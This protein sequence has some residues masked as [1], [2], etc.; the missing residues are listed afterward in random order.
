MRSL[1]LS[2]ALLIFGAAAAT[3]QPVSD[4]QLP[5][6]P[7]ATPT[8][9]PQAQG[10]TDLEG[11]TRSAPRVI[12]TATPEPTATARPD[13]STPSPAPSPTG[14]APATPSPRQTETG[15]RD[16]ALPRSEGAIST[17]DVL[18]D[19]APQADP[20]E[21]ASPA[22]AND[23]A[24]PQP[25][26]GTAT[27]LPTTAEQ[28][29]GRADIEAD[30]RAD[31]ENL[32]G[33]DTGASPE[34]FQE[35]APASVIPAW[36]WPALL[37]LA[38]LVLGAI[39][40]ALARRRIARRREAAAAAAVPA[41]PLRPVESPRPRPAGRPASS[42][43]P[44][45]A[46]A[47]APGPGSLE[48]EAFAVTL[49]RS[50]MNATISYRVTLTNR[51]P[52]PITQIRVHG[53][54]TTAHGRI[55]ADQQLADTRQEFPELHEHARLK[56]GQRT[57]MQGQLR[58]PLQEVRAL[59]QGNVPV[60]VPLLRLA[61]RAAELEPRAYTYVIGT[62]ESG[63]GA[64]PTPFRLDEGPRNYAQLSTRALA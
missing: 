26:T 19:R 40:F 11:E 13:R 62:R 17:R 48:V 61:V 29:V 64:R 33:A 8:S 51:G 12:G 27:G 6:D 38:V 31:P 7:D 32:R 39:I 35:P 20:V 15:Q 36:I 10:P 53:D 54:V 60:F 24:A 52:R 1:F 63:K 41:E 42:P 37:G 16:R 25:E 21:P 45:S 28:A 4:F 34:P 43:T 30:M 47:R 55:P 3:A 22:A 58:I 49:N 23:E 18:A 44:T 57:T 14:P 5:P 2:A 9:R 46:P 50:V 56:A 59:H